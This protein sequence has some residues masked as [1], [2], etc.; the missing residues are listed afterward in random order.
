MKYVGKRYATDVNDQVAKAYT[1]WDADVRVKLPY[2]GGD[3]VYLQA[4]VKNLTDEK[5]LGSISTSTNSIALP[6][7][8][9]SQPS[10]GLGSPRTYQ[11]SLHVD[12]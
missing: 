5:Y 6:G 7:S 10:Y 3:R 1:T 12:F 9:A 11:F 4:N 2:W 8:S